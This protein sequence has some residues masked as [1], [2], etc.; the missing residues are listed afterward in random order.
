MVVSS[1][2]MVTE[3]APLPAANVPYDCNSEERCCMPR[4]YKGKPA[5]NFTFDTT[6]PMRVRRPVHLLD[7]EY[8]AKLE[9]AYELIRALP[10]TDPRSLTNQM[11]L[12]CLYCD[13][14]IYYPNVTF[15]LEI[16]NGWL[17]LP[18]HRMF[19]YFHERILAKLLGDD[20]FALPYW[21]WDNQSPYPPYANI[22]PHIYAKKNSSLWNLNR[23]KCSE[24]SNIIDLSTMGGCTNKSAS[25]LRTNN[26]RLMYT[27]LVDGAPL[28]S[29][30]Y[31]MPYHLGDVGGAGPGTFEDNPHGTVH[32]WVGDPSAPVP[33]ND[34]GNFG[35]SARDPVFYAHHANVDRIWTIW[36]TIPGGIR[37]DPTSPDWQ[38]SEFTYYDEDANL[39]VVKVSQVLDIDRLRYVCVCLYM[40]HH[41]H[42]CTSLISSPAWNVTVLA[43][44]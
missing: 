27:Q 17:F 13:N 6:L 9:R 12:H 7:K 22:F 38:N 40:S 42:V 19:I 37:Q 23:N 31:G 11:N 24:P 39:V 15:P 10:D 43:S 3:A 32:A 2:L 44:F 34:M 18:W 21:N 36:K 8:I 30:F 20:T 5:K 1:V 29:L 16:H 41:I 26:Q 4:P 25:T 33:F 35:V 28:P 14:G